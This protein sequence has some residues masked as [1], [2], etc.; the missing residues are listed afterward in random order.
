MTPAGLIIWTITIL[1]W[2]PLGVFMWIESY[3]VDGVGL[4]KYPTLLYVSS[5][6]SSGGLFFRSYVIPLFYIPAW[7]LGRGGR[8]PTINN[9]L[10]TSLVLPIMVLPTII[11]SLLVF[12]SFGGTFLFGV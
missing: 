4:V 6:L 5:Q 3:R 10:T 9:K 12:S 11:L 7:I 1:I 2:L 8:N